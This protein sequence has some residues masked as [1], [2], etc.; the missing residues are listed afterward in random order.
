MKVPMKVLTRRPVSV[1]LLVLL[2]RTAAG[3]GGTTWDGS[4]SFYDQHPEYK[5]QPDYM[6]PS[7]P[8]DNADEHPTRP[9]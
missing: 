6:H 1:A 7:D 2:A 9:W 8:D 5:T 3:C 4:T